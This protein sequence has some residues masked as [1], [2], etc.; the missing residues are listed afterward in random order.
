VTT[1]V[2]ELTGRVIEAGSHQG[3]G[4][5]A[6]GLLILLLVQHAILRAG[7]DPRAT[8]TS[9]AYLIAIVPLFLAFG[10]VVVTRLIDVLQS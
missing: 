2:T 10:S 3:V 6:V 4:V 5:V 8:Q 1:T 9:R 7:G